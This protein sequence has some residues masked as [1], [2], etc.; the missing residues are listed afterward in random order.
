M[1][2]GQSSPGL[3]HLLTAMPERPRVPLEGQ[4]R[5]K[6]RSEDKVHGPKAK[7]EIPHP[8]LAVMA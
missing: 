2:W 3:V 7:S 1:G 4:R 8:A 6:L 5:E